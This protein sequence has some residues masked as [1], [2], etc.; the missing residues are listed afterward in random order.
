VKC[1]KRFIGACGSSSFC[2]FGVFIRRYTKFYRG[3][4]FRWYREQSIIIWRWCH[5]DMGHCSYFLLAYTDSIETAEDIGLI[6]LCCNVK[7]VWWP[8]D[9]LRGQGTW[10][11]LNLLES[12][13]IVHSTGE[14]D[15]TGLP[16]AG[17]LRYIFFKGVRTAKIIAN[18]IYIYT[19]FS[20]SKLEVWLIYAFSRS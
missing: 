11:T 9:S 2:L 4:I 12:W 15:R 18:A 6:N 1:L 10:E 19:Y 3:L 5:L 7:F 14:T 20:Y 16:L 8:S 13:Y 17:W